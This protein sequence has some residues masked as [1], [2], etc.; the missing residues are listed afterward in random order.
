[1]ADGRGFDPAPPAGDVTPAYSHQRKDENDKTTNQ[2]T[3]EPTNQ[4]TNEPTNRRTDEPTNRRT[5]PPGLKHH[6]CA[7]IPVDNSN[8]SRGVNPLCVWIN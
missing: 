8:I 7:P 2:P 6:P 5:N 3:N 1:M 4:R